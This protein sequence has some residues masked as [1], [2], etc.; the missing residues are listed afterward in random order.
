[1]LI[2]LKKKLLAIVM[3]LLLYSAE[4]YINGKRKNF[5]M[6]SET[7]QHQS[8]SSNNSFDMDHMWRMRCELEKLLL[9]FSLIVFW[10]N[11]MFFMRY[12]TKSLKDKYKLIFRKRGNSCVQMLL[13]NIHIYRY[14]KSNVSNGIGSGDIIPIFA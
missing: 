3:V 11:I 8:Y 6:I 13:Q 9:S 2:T 1:M 4:C 7:E 10:V 14:S 5:L 12:L